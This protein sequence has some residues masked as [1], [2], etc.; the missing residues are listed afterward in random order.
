[1]ELEPAEP[2]QRYCTST[3][4]KMAAVRHLE[5][6]KHRILTADRIKRRTLQ[7]RTSSVAEI[8]PFSF[9]SKNCGRHHLGDITYTHTHTHTPV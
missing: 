9:K 8:S 3:V 7:Y 1:M 6:K 4:S 2:L 5:F